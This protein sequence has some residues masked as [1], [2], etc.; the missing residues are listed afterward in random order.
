MISSRR[1]PRPDELP[2]KG[3]ESNFTKILEAFLLLLTF[4]FIASVKRFNGIHRWVSECPIKNVDKNVQHVAEEVCSAVTMAS[5][6]YPKT[7]ACLQRSAV[8]ARMLSRRGVPA[9]V[10]IGVQRFPFASHAWVEISGGTVVND[11]PKVKT[12][13]TELDRFGSMAR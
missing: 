5:S 11:K 13:Y 12:L 9:C 8:V 1:N 4:D 7:V 3:G 2:H 10:V 6:Y